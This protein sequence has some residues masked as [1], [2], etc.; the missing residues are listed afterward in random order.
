MPSACVAAASV[1]AVS[2]LRAGGIWQDRPRKCLNQA[3]SPLSPRPP[4]FQQKTFLAKH[5]LGAM[6]RVLER[7]HAGTW[8]ES[9]TI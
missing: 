6:W 5:A 7:Y 8:I 1:L 9:H 3:L 2:A 4:Q